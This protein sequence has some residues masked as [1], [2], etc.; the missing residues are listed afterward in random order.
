MGTRRRQ[1]RARRAN[2]QRENTAT[3]RGEAQATRTEPR[4]AKR[5]LMRRHLNNVKQ[6]DLRLRSHQDVHG[7][8]Q[9]TDVQSIN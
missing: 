4:I 7:R 2:Y 6:T 3:Y 1:T 9:S 5:S 8:V